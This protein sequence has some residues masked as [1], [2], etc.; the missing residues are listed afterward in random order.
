MLAVLLCA[1]C[2]LAAV[3]YQV[4]AT[5]SVKSQELELCHGLLDILRFGRAATH[6]D[7][8]FSCTCAFRTSVL[9]LWTSQKE[10]SKGAPE[11]LQ[12]PVAYEGEEVDEA[13]AYL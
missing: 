9:S 11:P 10:A 1:L 13:E 8:L 5:Q 2:G 7:H 3:P 12:G 6:S 4:P